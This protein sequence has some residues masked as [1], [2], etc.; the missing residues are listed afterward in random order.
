VETL[1]TVGA[2]EGEAWETFGSVSSLAFDAD[3]TLFVLDEAVGH[4][5]AVDTTGSHVRTISNEGDGPGELGRP[6]GLAVFS[7]G[8][9]GVL[10]FAKVGLQLFSRD[11]TFL[12]GIRFA[13]EE[14]SRGLHS[15]C[16]RTTAL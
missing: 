7:D 9:I 10:D 15:M 6:E 1:Y 11:G 5:V 13:N 3:G 14:E 16:C 4:I 2:V 12:E 8:R